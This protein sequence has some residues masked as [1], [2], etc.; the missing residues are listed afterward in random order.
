MVT[1]FYLTAP[2]T[3][4]ACLVPLES[5]LEDQFIN[6][7]SC[8]TVRSILSSASTLE[9]FSQLMKGKGWSLYL[10]PWYC[11]LSAYAVAASLMPHLAA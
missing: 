3:L 7:L 4:V 2:H 9:V 6:E 1:H 11:C 10:N 5:K 8:M